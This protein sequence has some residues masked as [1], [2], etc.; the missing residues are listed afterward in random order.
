MTIWAIADLHLS[1]GVPNKKMDI[2]GPRWVNHPEKV[3]QHWLEKVT[4]D[5]L[6]LIAGDISWAKRPQDA[7][8]DLNWIH[9]LPGTKVMI[10][11]NHDYWWESLKKLNEI[12][13]PSIHVIQNNAFDWND[14]SVAGCRMWDTSEYNFDE[15]VEYY[16]V[17]KGL[18][19][20]PFVE[21]D[22]QEAEKI[23]ERELLRLEMSLKCLNPKARLRVVMTH[24]P[25]IG[26]DLK[27][28][29]ISKLLAQYKVDYCIFGHLHSV[30]ENSLP[31]GTA[32]GVKYIF[33]ACDYLD[34]N[35]VKVE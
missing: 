19:T 8:P 2:F 20:R 28:S 4:A 5:D 25:P 13:P 30:K 6:V 21:T 34:C 7:I 35:P 32:D 27:P 9:E 18:V 3:K 15:K 12:T 10:R 22:W 29:R 24:Y 1:F 14:V 11:G 16:E 31:F 33:T 17:P 23:F 26:P